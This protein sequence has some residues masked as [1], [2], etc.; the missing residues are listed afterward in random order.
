MQIKSYATNEIVCNKW[1]R[2]Q[3]MKSY[4][5]NEIVCNKWNRMQQMNIPQPYI[6]IL[7]FFS[8]SLVWLHHQWCKTEIVV[9]WRNHPYLLKNLSRQY[10]AV[11][12]ALL[13]FIPYYINGR[14]CSRFYTNRQTDRHCLV[15][16]FLVLASIS[17]EVPVHT[18]LP[19]DGQSMCGISLA[20][21]CALASACRLWMWERS[22]GYQLAEDISLPAGSDV[23]TRMKPT[24]VPQIQY[25]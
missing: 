10:T 20:H 17:Y 25:S 16:F 4:A 5:T 19:V 8:L 24:F 2:M 7:S 14:Y 3:Q 13:S 23:Q 21:N 9:S 22:V 12:A 11:V 6:Q 18:L 15:P 1:N